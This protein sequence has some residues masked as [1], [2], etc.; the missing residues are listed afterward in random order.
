MSD[1]LNIIKDK[2]LTFE[3]RVIALARAAENSIDVLGITE[4]IQRYRDNGVIC[5]LFEG[6]APYRPRYI[7]PDYNKFMEQGS[8]FLK[9]QP[10]TDIWEAVNNL[11]IL[12][13]HVPSI[14]TFPVYIGN[15]DK[16]LEPF[17]NDEEEA[18]KAIKF[19]ML[20]ID[21]TITDSFCHANIGPERTKAGEIILRV[22]RELEVPIPNITIKYDEEIT[23]NDFAIN[24]I[25]TALIT[26]KPSFANHKMF[27]E[28]LEDYG[29]ASCYNGLKIGGGAHTLVRMNFGR[30]V[31]LAVS[32]EH[33]MN[34]LFPDA[35]G[36]MLQYIDMRINFLVEESGFFENHFL[37]KEGL[38]NSDNFTA[39]FGEVGIA[40]CVNKLLKCEKLEEKFGHSEVATELGVEIIDKLNE[41]VN[42]HYNKHCVFTDGKF[43]LHAQVGIDTDNG[44]APGCRIPIGDEPE[45]FDHLKVCAK[46]HKYFPSGIGDIFSFDTTVKKNPQ[47]ILDIIKGS[48][49]IGVRYFSPYASD[50]D[51]IRITGYLVKKSEIEKIKK[52][53]AVLRDTTVLGAGAAENQRVLERK[54]RSK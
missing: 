52:G 49:N 23:P 54:T 47:Y 25:N 53:E 45:I 30:L 4:E 40:D 3:Q 6:N 51:V 21:R 9:L 16:L 35:V 48:F 37:V 33:F 38:I 10:P 27:T 11:L 28:D 17:V 39:M 18:Y 19:L 15:I 32:K 26:A 31:D 8:E 22:Q 7:V 43:M 50:C 44:I 2:T 29:I 34:E 42:N 20:H 14:T 41:M 46:F 12:Y 24:A 1:V 5:D 36:K 13:K